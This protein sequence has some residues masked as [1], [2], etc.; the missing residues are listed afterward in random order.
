MYDY[1]DDS[2]PPPLEDVSDPSAPV[3]VHRPVAVRPGDAAA[4]K[5]KAKVPADSKQKEEKKQDDDAAHDPT[6]DELP[7]KPDAF[8]ALVCWACDATGEGWVMSVLVAV[9]S[10]RCGR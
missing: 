4:A 3:V 8:K 2:S 10:C 5:A 6:S 7:P 1:R 9:A